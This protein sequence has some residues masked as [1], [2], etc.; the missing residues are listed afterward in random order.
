MVVLLLTPIS[1][2]APASS[3]TARIAL[4]IRVFLMK[5]CRSTMHTT[6]STMVRMVTILVWIFPKEIVSA[7]KTAGNGL[8]ADEKKIMKRFSRKRLT[9]I[10]VMRTESDGEPR[11]GL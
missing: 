8:D 3:L 10:A 5:S 1:I 6:D 9:A 4:P 2:A 7:E 11:S